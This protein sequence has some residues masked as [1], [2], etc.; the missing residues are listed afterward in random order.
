MTHLSIRPLREED[1]PNIVSYWFENS[2]ADLMRI[3]VDRTKLNSQIEF[4]NSLQVV[5]NTPLDKAKSYYMAWLIDDKP[6]GYN[7]LKDIVKDEIASMHLH[8]WN[9]EYRGKGY[10]AKLFCMAAVEFYS[11]FNLKMILCEPRSSNPM[12]NKMLA[13]IGFKKWRTYH[14]TS[15]ELSLTCELNSYII[16]HNIAT[17]FLG[18]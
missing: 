7:A 2:D 4:A 15:S 3:G 5:C 1:I 6:I 16:D 11:M 10:G 12:P 13:K 18:R 14:S 9:T 8:M 17:N